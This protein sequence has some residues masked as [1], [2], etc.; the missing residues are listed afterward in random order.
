MKISQTIPLSWQAIELLE[1][2]KPIT[3]GSKYIFASLQAM[4][5]PIS[6]NGMLS[7]IY[8]MGW[9]G[10]TTVH[11]VARSTFSTIANETLKM[12]PDAIEATLAHKVKDPVRGDYN[13]ATYLDERI[14]DAQ[15]WADYLDKIKK[16]AE[17]LEFKKEA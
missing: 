16:G 13:H 14:K 1:K 11:G 12:R 8:N 5:K 2:I 3:E 9:K 7:V 10:K 4:S 6:E 17:V 15:I